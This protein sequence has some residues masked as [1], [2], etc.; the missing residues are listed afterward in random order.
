MREWLGLE[1]V[2]ELF[3]NQ[4]ITCGSCVLSTSFPDAKL[5][6]FGD[7]VGLNY[8]RNYIRSVP[9]PE[10]VTWREWF[11]RFERRVRHLRRGKPKQGGPRPGD[12]AALPNIEPHEYYLLLP[13]LLDHKVKRYHRV[14]PESLA[15]VF[16][17][18]STHH[19][20]QSSPDIAQAEAALR[21]ASQA[22]IVLTSNY[23]ETKR[24]AMQGEIDSYCELVREASP[25]RS[26]AVII[27]P[28]PRDS[29]DKIN[30]LRSRLQRDYETV[31]VLDEPVTF[32]APLEALVSRW[33]Q[34][35]PLFN[36]KTTMICVSSSCLGLEYLYGCRT[37]LGFGPERVKA[38]FAADW[39]SVR[40]Q[41]ERDLVSALGYVRR[42]CVAK[43]A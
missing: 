16:S 2:D 1:H 15:D 7:G 20:L 30:A 35:I 5:I 9:K 25:D 36:Q 4:V 12:D 32:Y 6:G 10:P 24:M 18:F 42:R 8:S 40:L 31:L 29:R 23:A 41:H 26:A 33:V 27:K 28:H 21:D 43:A 11:R 22:V 34:T 37:V 19:A 13:N 38:H 3:L 14:E 17:Q 39:Q